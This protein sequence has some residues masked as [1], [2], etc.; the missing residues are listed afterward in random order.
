MQSN[1]KSSHFIFRELS[2]STGGGFYRQYDQPKRK[3]GKPQVN[4]DGSFRVRTILEPIHPLKNT[5]KELNDFLK[6]FP[7]PDC[8]YGGIQ[9]RNNTLNA[10]QHTGNTNF[11]TI[12][13]KN[14]FGNITNS[15]IHQTLINCGLTWSEARIITRLT[16]FNYSLPQGAPTSTILSNLAFASCASTLEIF[17]KD[18]NI[19]FT[20]FVDDLTFSST[21]YFKHYTDQILKIL[22]NNGFYVNQKKIHYRKNCCEITGLLVKNGRLY[23]PKEMIAHIN[24][25]GIK[26]YAD[27]VAKMGSAYLSM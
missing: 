7:L 22:F 3:F 25:P 9:G 26:R 27:H 19:T 12:D 11:L 5:Q 6:G 21:R 16:T 14:F 24:K 8:M 20:V 2:Q 17:C 15:C 18:R 23:L 1:L 4:N 10:L 13:L